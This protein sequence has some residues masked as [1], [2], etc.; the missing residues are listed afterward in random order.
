MS[1]SLLALPLQ[2]SALPLTFGG[3]MKRTGLLGRYS[4]VVEEGLVA[5]A[6]ICSDESGHSLFWHNGPRQRW[7]LVIEEDGV[8]NFVY[9][10]S[11]PRRGAAQS[12]PEASNQKSEMHA[13]VQHAGTCIFS[14]RCREG[15]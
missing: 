11:C 10:I 1:E 15:H 8:R 5:T 2:S 4:T 7:Q 9:C 14:T 12:L 3:Q 6:E 13:I